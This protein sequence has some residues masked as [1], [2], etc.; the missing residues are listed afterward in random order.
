MS[1]S[2]GPLS[3]SISH[4]LLVIAFG[5]ALL[6]GGIL[7]R[8]HRVPV[9]GSVVDIFVVTMLSA[10][11]GFVINYFEYY[12]NDLLGIIDIRDGGFDVLWGVLGAI[13]FTGFLMWRR[14][15]QRK[16]MAT[17]ALTGALF[18]AATAGTIAL[19]EQQARSMPDI[20]LRSLNGEAVSMSQLA[21]NQPLVVNLWAT[22]CPPCVREMPVLE[23]AQQAHPDITFV[24]ANQR[25]HPETIRSFLEENRLDLNNLY[26]DDQAQLAQAVGS[27]GLPTTL[28]YN[29]EGKLIDAHMGE[30]SRATLA[31]GLEKIR[32]TDK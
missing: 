25:E 31:R 30:L 32:T 4:L 26:R 6:V 8:Q 22:W 14:Q 20:A 11:I 19:I 9:A 27:H 13:I 17:A 15:A 16:L 1:V 12:Q 7:G 2:I 24:F 10:R 29:A 28:F 21:P 23:E 5:L 18:W 3:L